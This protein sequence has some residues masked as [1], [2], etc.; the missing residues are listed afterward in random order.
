MA[1]RTRRNLLLMGIKA[2]RR[3]GMRLRRTVQAATLLGEKQKSGREGSI[4]GLR[5]QEVCM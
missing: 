5:L 1:I 3:T 4:E 2:Y